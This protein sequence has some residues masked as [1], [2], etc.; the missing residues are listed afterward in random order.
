MRPTQAHACP[1]LV[2]VRTIPDRDLATL[3]IFLSVHGDNAVDLCMNSKS[4]AAASQLRSLSLIVA[5]V[6]IS[7]VV[8]PWM[9]LVLLRLTLCSFT[10]GQDDTTE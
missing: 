6:I 1:P 5:V 3:G 7:V 10:R 2:H 9:G 4:V 8:M